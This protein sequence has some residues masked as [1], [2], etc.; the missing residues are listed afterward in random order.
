MHHSKESAKAIV[1]AYNHPSGDSIPSDGDIEMTQ[2]LVE[3]GRLMNVPVLDHLI[4]GVP[5]EEHSGF[6]SMAASGLVEF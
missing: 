1:V 4:V 5:S 6:F 2:K 3:A